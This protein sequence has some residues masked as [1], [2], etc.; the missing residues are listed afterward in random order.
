M[1][2]FKPLM[3]CKSIFDI[4]YDILKKRNI[5][6]IIFDSDNTII[7]Y[8]EEV[9]SQKVAD[10]IT[11]LSKEFKIFIAS[12][13]IKTRVRKIGKF[14]NVHAFYSV[15]K[16][17]KKIKKLLLKKYDVQMNE[18][19]IIG[20]QL[21]TDIFMG[22]RLK[23]YTVLV[24]PMTDKDLKVTYFN[25]WLEKMIMKRIKLKRGEYYEEIL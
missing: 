19:A 1:S 3:Y 17:T 25:R 5:K 12:N 13:N 10:L 2:K 11:K 14:L 18:V 7:S 15:V 4:N 21:V 23:M 22:N 6:V 24:D 20:D 16:P 8:D 9:P